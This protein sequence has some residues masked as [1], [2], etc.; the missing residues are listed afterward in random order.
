MSLQSGAVPLWHPVT[1]SQVSTPSHGS[2]SLQVSGVPPWQTPLAT[3]HVSMPS[4][5]SPSLQSASLWQQC[6][7]GSCWQPFVW[8]HESLVQTTPSSQLGAVPGT[9]LP[10]AESQ[11]AM[12]LQTFPSSQSCATWW[13][14]CVPVSQVSSVHRSPSSQSASRLQQLAI[15]VNVQPVVASQPSSVQASPSEQVSG[16]PL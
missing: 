9:Q 2:P 3:S 4:Q 6:A 10:V 13:H 15:S 11:V 7:T 1:G 8:S 5:T 14:V 16:V 12:P